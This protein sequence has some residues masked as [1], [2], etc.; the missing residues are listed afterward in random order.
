[1]IIKCILKRFVI[2]SPVSAERLI[3]YMKVQIQVET[4]FVNA[5]KEKHIQ[6]QENFIIYLSWFK[7]LGF[8]G[9][10]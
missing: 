3:S 1:M 2:S 10:I 6:W 7:N 5:V 4:H 9:I 8:Y